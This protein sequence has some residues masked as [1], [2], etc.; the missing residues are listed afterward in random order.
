MVKNIVGQAV[1]QLV[2]LFVLIFAG[3][4]FFDIP[5]GRWAAFGSK[6]SQHFTIVFNTFVMMTLFNELNARKIYGE[7]N[8]FKGL[9]TN[10]L[11][12][13]IWISTMIGQFL[14][15]Q[16]G[17]SWFSTA[18]LSFEQWFICLALGIGTLLWQQVCD[19]F[20]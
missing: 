7:R 14:I 18:S 16:Y 12:C 13:S 9:F 10:P 1:Y 4:K 20:F 6:P 5:S 19:I 17:G 8:V 11:F 3:E 2:V 15:V